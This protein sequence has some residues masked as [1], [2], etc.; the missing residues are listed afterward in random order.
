MRA[1]SAGY[2]RAAPFLWLIRSDRTDN[3]LHRPGR[4]LEATGITRFALQLV[5]TP[6]LKPDRAAAAAV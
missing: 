5:C 2:A 4:G 3:A 1:G 6:R